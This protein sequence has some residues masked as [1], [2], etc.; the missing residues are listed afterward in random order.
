MYS[1]VILAVFGNGLMNLQ[2]SYPRRML[3]LSLHSELQHFGPLSTGEA[4][5]KL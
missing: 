2:S 3:V 1:V 4:H 5:W